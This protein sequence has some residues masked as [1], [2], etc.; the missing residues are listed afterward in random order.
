MT[1]NVDDFEDILNNGFSDANTSICS[2]VRAR[3]ECKRHKRSNSNISDCSDIENSK[4]P[5]SMSNRF[6]PNHAA[7][8]MEQA[9]HKVLSFNLS[10]S[11]IDERTNDTLSNDKDTMN[12]IAFPKYKL[13][14][15]GLMPIPRVVF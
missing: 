6:I 1:L 4:P 10:E 14:S 9:S 12:S 8:D 2:V 11:S 7:M 3:W 5:L 13:Q 15:T